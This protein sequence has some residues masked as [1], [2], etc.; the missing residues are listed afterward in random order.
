MTVGWVAIRPQQAV[1]VIDTANGLRDSASAWG[2]SL[3]LQGAAW[4]QVVQARRILEDVSTRI[5]LAS[6]RGRTPTEGDYRWAWRS[7]ARAVEMVSAIQTR[8]TPDSREALARFL[9]F[10]E[11]VERRARD[12]GEDHG[13]DA[14]W[15][16]L[17]GLLAWVAS[18]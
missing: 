5:H 16:V 11:L 3:R 6:I 15:V 14:G 4:D 7:M 17:L 13:R 12:A 2:A 9:E 8:Q 18:R 10:A 1:E